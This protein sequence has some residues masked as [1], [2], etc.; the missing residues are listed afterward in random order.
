MMRYCAG[1]CP[2][3]WVT[4]IALPNIVYFRK[5]RRNQDKTGEEARG[6]SILTG[7]SRQQEEEYL[8][9]LIPAQTLMGL[10]SYFAWYYGYGFYGPA[11][12]PLLLYGLTL[13][14]HSVSH[15]GDIPKDP[16]MILAQRAAC[17]VG[18]FL[19]TCCFLRVSKLASLTMLPACGVYFGLT[20]VTYKGITGN[21]TSNNADSD[22][23][24]EEEEE[25]STNT[26]TN[27]NREPLNQTPS[28]T[29][30]DVK[31]Q[32]DRTQL[33]LRHR[34]PYQR[35]RRKR[36]KS[37]LKLDDD[38]EGRSIPPDAPRE[39]RHSK[40]NVSFNDTIGIQYH[41]RQF[42]TSLSSSSLS[43]HEDDIVK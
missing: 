36:Q 41:Q 29:T 9:F 31:P 16:N 10:S 1:T 26:N 42:S 28:Q 19:C 13:A 6:S 25:T 23:E 7:I 2:C 22:E 27:A 20:Y 17:A 3:T 21:N 8:E 11:K 5:L 39:R 35:K 18:T 37:I 43:S 33:P 32:S 30:Q 4:A 15:E 38:A 40:T 34:T 12:Y 14:S 24:D